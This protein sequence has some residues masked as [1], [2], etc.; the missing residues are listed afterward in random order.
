MPNNATGSGMGTCGLVGQIMAFQTMTQS[1]YSVPSALIL[2]LFMHILLPGLLAF[3]ISEF[4]R[5]RGWIRKG[6]MKLDI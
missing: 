2:I 6:D 4:M 3:V 1:G 5:R